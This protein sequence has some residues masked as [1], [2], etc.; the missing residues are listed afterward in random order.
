MNQRRSQQNRRLCCIRAYR[1]GWAVSA[2]AIR[3]TFP[4]HSV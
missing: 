3:L 1:R 2:V 4:S